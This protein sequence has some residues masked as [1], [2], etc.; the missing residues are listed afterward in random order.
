MTVTTVHNAAAPLTLTRRRSPVQ[1]HTM[2]S[3]TAAWDLTALVKQIARQ[4]DTG[5]PVTVNLH[6]YGAGWWVTGV[7]WDRQRLTVRRG[8][9]DPIDVAWTLIRDHQ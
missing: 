4:V 2:P 8:S 5:Q 6:T 7:D 9:G 1:R 3:T